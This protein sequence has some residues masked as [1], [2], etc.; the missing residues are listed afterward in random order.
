[1][2]VLYK[3]KPDES[4]EELYRRYLDGDK[5][6]MEELTGLYGESLK[7]Y[8]H[9]FIRDVDTAEDLAIDAFAQL[10]TSRGQFEKRS[11]LKTY[12]FAIGKNLALRHIKIYKSEKYI[13]IDEVLELTTNEDGSPESELLRKE[14]SRQLFAAMRKLKPIHCEVLRLLYFEDNSYAQAGDA[15]NKTEIQIAN[16]AYR[17][18]GSLKAKLEK[19]GFTYAEQ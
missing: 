10:V 1:M 2:D 17:A 7:L 19:E 4:G 15:L 9:S 14:R 16:L 18:K 12:L 6:A 5:D 3:R 8:I 11:A 13:S